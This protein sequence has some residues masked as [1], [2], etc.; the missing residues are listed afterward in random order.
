MDRKPCQPRAEL[1]AAGQTPG[2]V[3]ARVRDG[4]LVR[5]RRGVYLSEPLP[6]APTHR[7]RLAV[8]AAFT[9]LSGEAVLSHGSAAVLHGL[10]V[11]EVPL[12]RVQVTRARSYGGRRQRLAHVRVARL[13]PDEIT[14]IDGIPVTTLARTVIDLARALPVEPAVAVGDAA[15]AGGGTSA[16]EL[17]D[18]L[19]RSRHRPG[20]ARARRVVPFLDGRSESVGESRSRLAI[21]R[22]GLPPPRPQVEIRDPD[23]GWLVGRVDFWWPGTRVVGEFDGKVKYGR[24][25]QPG[26]DPGEIVFREKLREDELRALG[27][28]VV[29]WIWRDLG[30]FGR[31]AAQLHRALNTP[32]HVRP[33]PDFA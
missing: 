27:L 21:A 11:W 17:A 31:K 8:H 23:D 29:R 10:P 1:L 4:E 26:E 6:E 28:D 14:E 12:G 3:R 16:E 18:M 22:A 30:S 20:C 24:G 32:E 33:R 9:A 5:I 13:D 19:N 2:E 25:R 7:H 15:L